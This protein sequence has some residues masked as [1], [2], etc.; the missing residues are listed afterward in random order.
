EATG[1]V[2]Q[3]PVDD[4][5]LVESDEAATRIAALDPRRVSTLSEPDPAT[6]SS[7]GRIENRKTQAV[8]EELRRAAIGISVVR[9]PLQVALRAKA[10]S[11]LSVLKPNTSIDDLGGMRSHPLTEPLSI[12]A[13][14]ATSDLR[15]AHEDGPAPAG[16]N[17]Y[18]PVV[19]D[20]KFGFDTNVL[21]LGERVV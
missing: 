6:V 13:I 11:E 20:R 21:P 10:G 18:R 12:A 3:R 15:A 16:T 5:D 1:A 9:R 8:V 2:P 19:A 14:A 17:P 4:G 7:T